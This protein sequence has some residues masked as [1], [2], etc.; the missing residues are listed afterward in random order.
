[1]E[2]RQNPDAN[3]LWRHYIE[4]LPADMSNFPIFWSQEE[5]K[6]LKGCWVYDHVHDRRK[7]MADDYELMATYVPEFR[8]EY[9]LTEFMEAKIA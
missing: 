5:L 7:I 6:W 4:I 2:M 8:F 1:M 9:S 3:P